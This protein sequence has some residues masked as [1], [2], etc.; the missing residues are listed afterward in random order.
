MIQYMAFVER[1]RELELKGAEREWRETWAGFLVLRLYHLWQ[2]NP[3]VV[4]PNAPGAKSV[5]GVVNA[6][7]ASAPIKERL[8]QILDSLRAPIGSSPAA[9]KRSLSEYA[10][11]LAGGT[12]WSLVHEVYHT[13]GM[14]RAAMRAR[15]RCLASD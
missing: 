6:L 10:A 14:G 15:K 5:R 3:E 4:H 8:V 12:H 2:L 13:A 11:G 1:L 9:I 7:P